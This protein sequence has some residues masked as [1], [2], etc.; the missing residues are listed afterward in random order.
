MDSMNF[1]KCG[2]FCSVSSKT[3]LKR[4]YFLQFLKNGQTILF[5]ANGFNKGLIWP[6]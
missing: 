5:L 4:Y 2:N 1:I 3:G 6:F